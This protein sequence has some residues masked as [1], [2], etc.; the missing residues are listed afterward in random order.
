[1]K[2]QNNQK[3]SNNTEQNLPP[4]DDYYKKDEPKEY[5]CHFCCQVTIWI[6]QTLI[7]ILLIASIK[8]AKSNQNK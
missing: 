1:M 6:L 8:T 5:K 2:E 4:K 7:W 3:A